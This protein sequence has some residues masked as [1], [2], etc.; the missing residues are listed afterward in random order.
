MKCLTEPLARLANRQ[1]K[2]RGA[3]FEGR[4]K[5]I[6][7]LDEEALL[8]TCT[9]IDLNPVAAGIANVPESSAH[10]SIKAGVDH[11]RD[12]GQIED[13]SAAQN[14]SVPA[15][16]TVAGLLERL[17]LG[18]RTRLIPARGASGCIGREMHSLA[19]RAGNTPAPLGLQPER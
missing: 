15:S 2:T 5:S 4:F 19:L 13:L 17:T 16:A 10:T 6:A 3:F 11:V 18:L 7:I 9:Y 8:A 1:D 12:Q 14:S